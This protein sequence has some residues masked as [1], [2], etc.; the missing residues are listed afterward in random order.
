MLVTGVE[1]EGEAEAG[2]WF[3]GESASYSPQE[4]CFV[5]VRGVFGTLTVV[6][7]QCGIP[8]QLQRKQPLTVDAIG[9]RCIGPEAI[10]AVRGVSTIPGTIGKEGE[11]T[12]VHIYSAVSHIVGLVAEFCPGAGETRGIASV[13][14]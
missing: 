13:L 1:G 12:D 11:E 6:L 4:C 9:K 7:L 2:A 10:L 14:F 8:C 3:E 5:F